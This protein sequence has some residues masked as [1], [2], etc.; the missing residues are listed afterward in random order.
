[1]VSNFFFNKFS[2]NTHSRQTITRASSE[3]LSLLVFFLPQKERRHKLGIIQERFFVLYMSVPVCYSMMS[4]LA[5][6][7]LNGGEGGTY[8]KCIITNGKKS[9]REEYNNK[10]LI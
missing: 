3:I 5:N 7:F 2:S 1:L 6:E 4:A 10:A 8:H 9:C